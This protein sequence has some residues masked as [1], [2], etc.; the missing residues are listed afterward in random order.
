M[1]VKQ[2]KEIQLDRVR[3]QRI[4]TNAAKDCGKKGPVTC[5]FCKERVSCTQ[6]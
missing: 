2:S 5:T 3:F 6:K 4:L 1:A